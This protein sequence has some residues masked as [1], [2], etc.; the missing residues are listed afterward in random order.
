MYI[1]EYLHK[2]RKY[3]ILV[4]V[5]KTPEYL[6]KYILKIQ[7][8][9]GLRLWNEFST[10]EYKNSP[11]IGARIEFIKNWLE[12]ECV[13]IGERS[14]IKKQ[15][16]NQQL[17]RKLHIG[18]NLDIECREYKFKKPKNYNKFLRRKSKTFFKTWP[19]QTRYKK[20]IR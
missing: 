6:N 16:I 7:G 2:F 3:A 20:Y 13:S 9:V 11:Y 12:R 5:D 10:F 14:K 8:P 15:D 1:K 4:R 17:R 18:E 19:Y